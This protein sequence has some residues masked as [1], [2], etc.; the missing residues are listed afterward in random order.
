M[1]RNLTFSSFPP[2]VAPN[3]LSTGR[4]NSVVL[5]RPHGKA[6]CPLPCVGSVLNH[7]VPLLQLSLLAGQKRP[8]L[9][10]PTSL[11]YIPWYSE[12]PR[13]LRNFSILV[14]GTNCNELGGEA[15]AGCIPTR[16]ASAYQVHTKN[17]THTPVMVYDDLMIRNN[18]VFEYNTNRSRPVTVQ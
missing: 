10:L 7:P 15:G 14:T 4:S 11:T 18:T 1:S 16:P 17:N 2:E 8:H 13:S 3:T 6:L 9:H 5:G 12:Q